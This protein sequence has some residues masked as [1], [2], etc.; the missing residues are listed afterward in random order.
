MSSY[1]HYV[2]DE[3]FLTAYNNYQQR[4]AAELSERDKV[5]LRLIAEKTGGRASLLDIGCSTGNLLLHISHAFPEMKLT[6]G[7]LAESSL[8][9]ARQNPELRTVDFQIMD[10]L[11][12]TGKYDCIVANAVC[13]MLN[14]EE[15]EAALRSVAAALNPGG[16]YISLEWLHPFNWQDLT[17]I[18]ESGSHPEGLKIHARPYQKVMKIMEQ[19]GLEMVEFRSFTMPSDL[20]F[21]GYDDPEMNS[22]TVPREGGER[23]CFR[24]ALC[25]PWCHVIAVKA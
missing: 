16:C 15:Y 4:F 6:G 10:M 24:G 18:E 20:P 19:V 12:I 5:I 13:Q 17:I 22:Y 1:G 8:T 7:E 3:A 9:V 14:G 11:A 25:Q 23:L 21:K 2:K